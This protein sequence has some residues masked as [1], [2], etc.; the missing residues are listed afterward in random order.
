MKVCIAQIKSEKGNIQKNI[1]NHIKFIKR[2]IE[3]NSDFVVFPEL[4]ITNY[5]PELANKLATDFDDSI[6]NLFQ[7]LSDENKITIGIGMPTKTIDGVNISMLIF[8]PSKER[9]VYSKRLLH[10]DELPYF[11]SSN[12]QPNLIIKGKNIALGIC[13]ETLQREHFVK[14]KENNA[15]LYI[16]SVAKPDRGINKAYLHFPSIAKEFETPILMCN[17]IGYSDNF[18]ANG[19]SSVW[20]SSGELI[21]QLNESDEGIIIWDTKTEKVEIEQYNKSK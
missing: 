2:V 8:Q 3:L 10:P 18:I 20:N 16:A 7:D 13:Y 17:S 12:K 1:Q 19:L 14:A 5:E 15:E 21:G 9:I 11:V 6:F 4:S